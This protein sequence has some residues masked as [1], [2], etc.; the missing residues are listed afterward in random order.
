MSKTNET[1]ISKIKNIFTGSK[2]L[3]HEELN[4]VNGAGEPEEFDWKPTGYVTPVKEQ[5]KDP[6]WAFSA[7]DPKHKKQDN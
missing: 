7:I 1:F 3:N 2:K 6:D 5:P 4:Q